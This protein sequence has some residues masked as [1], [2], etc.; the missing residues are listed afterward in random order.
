[1]NLNDYRELVLAQREEQRKAN[2]AKSE[3]FL[4]TLANSLNSK[5][6]K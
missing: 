3:A 4:A 2:L 6:G 5:E 1:M